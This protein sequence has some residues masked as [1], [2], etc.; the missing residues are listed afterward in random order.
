MK[1]HIVVL[2][3]GY[4]GLGAAKR[5]ARLLRRTDA[6]VTLV[7]DGDRFVQRI[8]LHELVAGRR[9][10]ELPLR[11]LLAGTGVAF[12]RARVTSIDPE[13][14]TVRLDGPP[15]AIGYDTLVCALGSETDV[16]GVPGVA[17]HAGTVAVE[18]AASRLRERVGRLVRGDAVAVVGGG[19]TGMETAAELAYARPDLRVRLVT[20]GG[21]GD[22]LSGRA[23]RYLRSAFARLGVTLQ[24]ETPVAGVKEGRLLVGDGAELPF[25]LLVWAAGFRVPEP[26]RA[27]GF[28]VDERGRM[29]VDGMLRSVS[30]PDVYAA[31]DA[32]AAPAPGGVPTRMSCQAGIPMGL[33]AAAVIA[34]TVRGREPRP[35]RLRY[36]WQSVSLG[37][38]DGVVQFTRADDGPRDLVLTGRAAALMKEAVS[39]GTVQVMR[40]PS[41]GRYTG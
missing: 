36:V 9:L 8:R 35:F 2:G 24:E 11:D 34:D 25:D 15:H 37:R 7:N 10:P 5:A 1:H 19:L 17:E 40:H 6:R 18:S 32:A 12:V 20:A 41:L 13:G 38:G 33:R 26:V 21:V 30:H 16:D 28:A 3:A 29:V 27:A 14:R 39:R 4:A 31:G 22:R 23:R